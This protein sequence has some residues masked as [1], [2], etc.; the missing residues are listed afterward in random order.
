MVFTSGMILRCLMPS[1]NLLIEPVAKPLVL[2]L[3]GGAKLRQ[4]GAGF[5]VPPYESTSYSSIAE[6]SG[7]PGA[8]VR[9]GF[10]I[11]LT[12]TWH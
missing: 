2:Q 3:A 5:G 6:D 4:A 7:R 10:A 8:D 9:W 11:T 12:A 1:C